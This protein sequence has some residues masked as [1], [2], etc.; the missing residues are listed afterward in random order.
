M[1]SFSKKDERHRGEYKK[2][3]NS[4]RAFNDRGKQVAVIC[5]TASPFETPSL[6]TELIIWYKE[7]IN[8][9]LIHP[10]LIISI[11]IVVFLEIHPFQDGNGR[12]SGVLTPLLLLQF[13]YNYVPYSSLESIIEKNNDYYHLNLRRT[14]TTIRKKIQTRDHGLPFFI[15]PKKANN[16]TS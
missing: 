12:I 16:S 8:D 14:Q 7:A 13:N 6:M 15:V 5:K 1:L 10:L 11:F 3:D 2:P 4:I 9:K